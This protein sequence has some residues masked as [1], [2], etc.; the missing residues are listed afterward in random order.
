VRKE[1]GLY[2]DKLSKLA[3]ALHSMVIKIKSGAIHSSA[4]KAAQKIARALGFSIDKPTKPQNTIP[5]TKSSNHFVNQKFPPESAGR[6]MTN[7]IPLAPSDATIADIE[8]MLFEKTKEFETINYIYIVDK[9]R[10]LKGVISV[11]DVFRLP[12]FTPVSQIM[13]R[14]LVLVHPHTDQE[15]V[16]LLALQHNLKAI[17]VVDKENYLLGIVPSDIILNILHNENIEDILRFAGVGVIKNPAISIIKASA[18][19]HFRKRLPWL[20]LGL[21]G[22]VAAAFIVEFFEDALKAQLILAAFIPAVVYMADAVGAQTQT[23]FIRSLALARNLNIKKYVG[24]EIKVNLF[25]ALVLGIIISAIS[26]LWWQSSLL[27]VILG[28]SIFMTILAAMAVAILLP[29][30][31]SKI[32]YDPAIA[33]GPFATVV[34]DILSLLIYFSI[35]QVMLNIFVM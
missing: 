17:P 24:R 30:L 3:D 15:M 8:K 22:G 19:L 12:K 32:N 2:Q 25:L 9:S 26:L 20:I 1:M 13:K 10:R 23:I 35:A 28:I 5:P 6:L 33:S 11:K 7:E 18:L 4:I 27:G 16:A 29:W 31:F 34:R 14:D 21:L